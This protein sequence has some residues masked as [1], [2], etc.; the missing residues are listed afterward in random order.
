MFYC[1]DCNDTFDKPRYIWEKNEFWGAIVS[2]RAE[3]CPICKSK[4]IV[5]AENSPKC[6][7]CGEACFGKYI[8]TYDSNYYCENCYLECNN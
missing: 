2:A 1:R 7:C 8:E 4:D 5:S 6:K 3:V